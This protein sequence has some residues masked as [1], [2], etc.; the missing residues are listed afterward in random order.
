MMRL[1]WLGLA[2]G[3][4]AIT[5]HTV[6]AAP[7]LESIPESLAKL[8]A[9]T[10]S[11]T[12]REELAGGGIGTLRLYLGGERS[13]VTW[14]LADQVFQRS[15]TQE[16]HEARAE[17]FFRLARDHG[18]TTFIAERDAERRDYLSFREVVAV[19]LSGPAR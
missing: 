10:V 12:T 15:F 4:L 11:P 19:Q 17:R 7:R 5:P 2:A 1:R 9:I 3:L 6:G 8:L 13:L 18:I 14:R 16:D